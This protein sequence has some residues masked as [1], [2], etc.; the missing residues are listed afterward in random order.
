MRGADSSGNQPLAAAA[1]AVGAG[2]RSIGLEAGFARLL[3]PGLMQVIGERL[4][5]L[6]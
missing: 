2:E 4:Q 3:T 5:A 6:R 1:Q